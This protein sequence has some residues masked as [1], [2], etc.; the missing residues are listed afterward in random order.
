[1]KA[2]NIYNGEAVVGCCFTFWIP[3]ADALP[4]VPI[5]HADSSTMQ[6]SS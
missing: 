3:I 5:P 2:Q 6:V 1:M 4:T